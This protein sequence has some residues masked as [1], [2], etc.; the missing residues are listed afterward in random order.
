MKKALLI[1]CAVGGYCLLELGFL[2]GM[3]TSIF[4]RSTV[5][6]AREEILFWGHLL[7]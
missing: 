2:L 6:R 4:W 5:L 7:P 3:L 1:L